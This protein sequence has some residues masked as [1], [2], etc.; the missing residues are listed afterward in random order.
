MDKVTDF[1]TIRVPPQLKTDY[2]KLD[3]LGKKRAKVAVLNALS[4]VCFAEIHY[5]P[6]IHFGDD[7][8]VEADD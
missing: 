1:T 6:S 4:R 3:Q 5:D 2:D 8:K 7:Y